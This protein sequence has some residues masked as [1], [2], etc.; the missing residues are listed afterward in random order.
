MLIFYLIK[1]LG[2]GDLLEC[3]FSTEKSESNYEN[4]KLH[5]GGLRNLHLAEISDPMN[6][7]LHVKTLARWLSVRGECSSEQQWLGLRDVSQS[8]AQALL[9]LCLPVTTLRV[10]VSWLSPVTNLVSDNN[11]FQPGQP[12]SPHSTGWLK[13]HKKWKYRTIFMFHQQQ[14][15]VF[16]QWT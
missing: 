7:R 16:S 11:L 5:W 6:A 3:L 13:I 8:R 15:V 4:V 9:C 14:Q 2:S 12:S 10:P 1:S